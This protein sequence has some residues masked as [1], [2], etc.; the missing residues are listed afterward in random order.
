MKQC[1]IFKVCNHDSNIYIGIL[2]RYLVLKH[3]F[4]YYMLILTVLVIVK[5]GYS[6]MLCTSHH[7]ITPT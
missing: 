1:S 7:S 3:N 5:N 6:A 4:P 2:K